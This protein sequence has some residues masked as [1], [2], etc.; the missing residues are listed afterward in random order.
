[1]LTNKT[2]AWKRTELLFCYYVFNCSESNHFRNINLHED[3]KAI[4]PADSRMLC[5]LSRLCR[6]YFAISL[7]LPDSAMDS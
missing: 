5:S 7:V 6:I 4:P 3:S 2:E 1:M